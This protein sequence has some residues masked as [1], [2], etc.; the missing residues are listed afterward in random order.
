MS[1][2]S[3]LPRDFKKYI[4]ISEFPSSI[5]DISFSL[6]DF[7][8]INDLDNLIMNYESP[9]IKERF[10]FDFYNN[11]KTGETKIGFRFTFQS[12]KKTV[13][14]KDV[15]KVMNEII[16]KSLNISSVSIPGLSV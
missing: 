8:K 1:L 10:I 7:T 12:S 11:I 4:A 15:D 3:N 9:L 2:P 5:R 6:K 16:N 14:D 13:T